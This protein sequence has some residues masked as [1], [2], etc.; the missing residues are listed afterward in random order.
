MHEFSICKN[1]VDAAITEYNNLDPPPRRLIAVR[2]VVGRLHQ[3]IRDS[4]ELAY[5][6]LTKDTPAENSKLEIKFVDV[7]CR[8][9]ACKWQGTIDYPF[10]ICKECQGGNIE[11]VTGKELYMENLEVEYE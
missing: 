3:I 4:L 9:P 8:C 6:V 11:V 10:F 1:I 2:I 5:D 7:E